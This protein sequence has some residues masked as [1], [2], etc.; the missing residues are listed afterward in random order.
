M[1]AEPLI[2]PK[3]IALKLTP[4]GEKFIQVHLLSPEH[5]TLSVLRR[6]RSK[7][8]NFSIDLFDQGEARIDHKPSEGPNKGFLTDF[9]VSKKRNGIGKSYECLQA[10][11]WLS[12]LFL[13]NPMHDETGEELFSV[14][15]RAL[16]ALNASA[17][18]QAVMLKALYLFARNEGYPVIQDWAHKLN[19]A[20]AGNV[21]NILNTPLSEIILDG[22]TQQSAFASLKRYVEFN[23]HIHLPPK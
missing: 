17:A 2:V 20:L 6:S 18:P 10:A 3:A 12:K 15:E 4:T 21:A 8:N 13:Q 7:A 16:D 23:T 22:E 14:A 5:G 1:P 11:S 19:P 9:F